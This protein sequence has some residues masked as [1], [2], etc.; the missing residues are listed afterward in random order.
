[1][2]AY[3]QRMGRSLMLPVATLPVAALFSGIG[4]WIDPTGWGANNIVAAFLLKAGDSILAN[5]GVLFAVGLALGMSKDRDGASALTGLVAFLVPMQLLNP[6]AIAAFQHIDVEKVN[7]AFTKMNNGNVFVGILAGLLAAAMYNRFS[8]VKLPMAL[9][10]FSGKRCVPIVTAALMLV[11]SA[12]LMFIWPPIFGALV[13]FGETIAKMGAVGAGLYGFFNR[14]LIPTGLHHALNNVFWFNTAGID[15]I[16]KFWANEGTKGITG[17]YQAGFFPVM[18]FGLPAGA[19]AIYRQSRP[20]KR[21]ATASLMLAAAFASF[22]TGVTEPLEFSFM[23]VAWPLYVVHAAL[24]GI[25]MFIAAL[26][27]WT[28]GFNFSAGLVDF[29]LSLRV[30]IANQPLM[31]VVLGLIM[32]VVYYFVFTFVIKTFNLMTPG[33]EEGEGEEDLDLDESF[34]DNKF[35][36]LAARIYTGLGGAENVVSIDNCTTRLRL[37][38]KD[39]AKA[40]QDKIKATGVP[41][42]RVIDKE[43]IQVI[44]GTEVQFVADEM[45]K[46][47]QNGGVSAATT[48]STASIVAPVASATGGATVEVYAPAQG[49]LVA[50][51]QVSDDV[52]SSK[53]MGNGFAIQPTENTVYTPIAGEISS[54]FPTQHALGIMTP[55]GLEVLLHM[56]V[57]TVDLKGEPFTMKVKAGQKVKAGDV[58]AIMDLAAVKAA[59]KGTDIIVA[60]TNGEVVD[61]LTLTELGKAVTPNQTIGQVTLK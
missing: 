17:M 27:H 48:T 55:T 37:V 43:N 45:N 29:V 19:Y 4:Y 36:A 18:M 2:K 46:M 52:F 53:I 38:V 7:A 40:D 3:M 34:A 24:T 41:G 12:G 35:A 61:Q 1:M 59:G 47:Q 58:I 60:L 25:S 9:S 56:G 33:R 54:I 14:L 50:I 16:G 51:D 15:D 44:V 6:A 10:F 22:F 5:L 49:T 11:V 42:V 13:A 31:L 39:T 23:F 32:A 8:N 26:F 30:P 21:K 57:D 28:A 20:E